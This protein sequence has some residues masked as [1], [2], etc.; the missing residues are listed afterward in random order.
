MFP[1]EQT[2]LPT[3]AI[4]L[5]IFEPRYR[6][7]ARVVTGLAEPEFGIAM[8]ERGREV[9]GDDERSSIGVVGRIVQAEEFPDGRWGIVAVATR[10]IRVEEWLADDPFPRATVSDWPDVDAD[11]YRASIGP[12]AR[13]AL[14]DAVSRVQV[15]SARLDPRHPGVAPELSDDPAQ[16]TW[17]AAVAARI[18]PLDSMNLLNEP[19]A[20]GR[21]P[22]AL[23][24]ILEQAEMLE[25]LADQAG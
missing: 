15:A 9:G 21:I 1:L 6:E 8:I 22:H 20:T 12:G 7:M 2:V 23:E 16:A 19:T 13:R 10:R 5:H 11:T 4:P 18:G 14:L 25:A 24:I 3:A 17:Q